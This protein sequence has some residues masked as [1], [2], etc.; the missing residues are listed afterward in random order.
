MHMPMTVVRKTASS[1]S[2]RERHPGGRVLN[3]GGVGMVDA[4]NFDLGPAA[5]VVGDAHDLSAFADGSFDRVI[6]TGMLQYCH[7]PHVV[8]S[9][10]RR[11]LKPGGLAYID[12]SFVQP[13][14][15]HHGVP[16]LWRFTPAGLRHLFRDFEIVECGSSIPAVSAL[17][18]YLSKWE[19]RS[20]YVTAAWRLCV[21]LVFAPL[22]WTKLG[23]SPNVAGALYLV[24]RR[25]ELLG[26]P[27][28]QVHL[29]DGL[30][31]IR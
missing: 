1:A 25:P 29:R 11:V 8:V 4:V 3:L 30:V 18:F 6:T 9:E 14:C 13:C 2:F 26:V 7:S 27:D 22:A 16:D 12:V 10:I 15:D 5:D 24:A 31:T 17:G 23:R 20:R 19:S 21:S 28:D